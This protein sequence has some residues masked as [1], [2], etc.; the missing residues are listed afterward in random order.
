MKTLSK[1]FLLVTM[2]TM[3][4]MFVTQY[5]W[6]QGSIEKGTCTRDIPA[7]PIDETTWRF[8]I[9]NPDN[10]ELF[11]FV[12]TK[13]EYVKFYTSM[14][15]DYDT[16]SVLFDSQKRPI[17]Q[18]IDNMDAMNFDN[19]C[20]L[21]YRV[22]EGDTYYLGLREFYG[23]SI[24]NCII[25]VETTFMAYGKAVKQPETAKDLNVKTL[26]FGYN[27][28]AIPAI[29]TPNDWNVADAAN[30]ELFE[31]VPEKSG[32]YS[33]S[34]VDFSHTM[35]ALFDSDK[36]A[37]VLGQ[38]VDTRSS[39]NNFILSCDVVAGK[40]YYV[41]VRDSYGREISK[42]RIAIKTCEEDYG[43]QIGGVGNDWIEVGKNIRNIGAV[44][45]DSKNWRF[46]A[47]DL[48]SYNLFKFVA[49]EQAKYNFHSEGDRRTAAIIYDENLQPLWLSEMLYGV[50]FTLSYPCEKGRTY[51][52]GVRDDV[53][54][55]IEKLTIIVEKT[56]DDKGEKFFAALDKNIVMG[57]NKREID[58]NPE[59]FDL[60]YYDGYASPEKYELYCF[61][62][63]KSEKVCFRIEGEIRAYAMLFD[64][65][66]Q[67][68]KRIYF[69][70]QCRVSYDLVE[71]ETYYYGVHKNYGSSQDKYVSIVV[72]P[73][74]EDYG[75]CPINPHDKTLKLGT[76]YKFL[77]STSTD[78]YYLNPAHAESPDK[79]D[80][81]EFVATESGRLSF[82]TNYEEYPHSFYGL[83]LDAELKP[84]W[85][86]QEVSGENKNMILSYDVVEG[87]TY[88][89]GVRTG[90]GWQV[91]KCPVIVE[92]CGKKYGDGVGI[93][94][95]NKI[96]YGTNVR[97]IPELP[98][99]DYYEEDERQAYKM[100]EFVAP[101]DGRYLF[102]TTGNESTDV[103]LYDLAFNLLQRGVSLW[104]ALERNWNGVL[105]F[106]L[107]K[108]ET[109][110]L[111]VAESWGEP[112][113]SCY[114]I[115]EKGSE[116]Y[117]LPGH[118]TDEDENN[119]FTFGNYTVDLRSE[120]SVE[121]F[122]N[123]KRYITVNPELQQVK[124]VLNNFKYEGSDLQNGMFIYCDNHNLMIELHGKN[125]INITDAKFFVRVIEAGGILFTGDG[126]LEINVAEKVKDC[127]A[128]CTET[129]GSFTREIYDLVFGDEELDE[130]E[131]D[132]VEGMMVDKFYG[133]VTV[134]NNASLY[135]QGLDTDLFI[136][137]S[138]NFELNVT[139][140]DS[141]ALGIYSYDGDYLV[142]G[143]VAVN[144]KAENSVAFDDGEM[145]VWNA[146]LE[147]N[148][149]TLFGEDMS[150]AVFE[151]RMHNAEYKVFAGKDKD[152]ATEVKLGSDVIDEL[153]D[154][155]H[156]HTVSV[157][158]KYED[159]AIYDDERSKEFFDHLANTSTME[160]TP[161]N[162]TV[163]RTFGSGELTTLCLP[164][165]V[166]DVSM[167]DIVAEYKSGSLDSYLDFVSTDCIKAGKPYLVLSKNGL[168]NPTFEKVMVRGSA[169]PKV[170][171]DKVEKYRNGV[172]FY[173]DGNRQTTIQGTFAPKVVEGQEYYY[174][175]GDDYMIH[176]LEAGQEIKGLRAY[177]TS[178]YYFE[179][180][181]SY[182]DGT[183]S[184]YVGV[185][186]VAL[187]QIPAG[188]DTYN[189]Q[190][191]RVKSDAKGIV[192]R[193]GKKYL[194]K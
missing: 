124:L 16:Y 148:A 175:Y 158:N 129:F 26:K 157:I 11:K 190:G 90:S 22:I 15:R 114:I 70:D 107:S 99:I 49:P 176:P 46:D 155:S 118:F 131:L 191:Q 78:W 189:L 5:S 185:D 73:C 55:A 188:G 162:V 115:V 119:M 24:P 27:D 193:N 76:N 72:E 127:S 128:L 136:W 84:L 6:A 62:A 173:D 98:A 110:Y 165:D 44:P 69:D 7:T 174:V 31:Y 132:F 102:Y 97:A 23:D 41:G 139:N 143:K 87:R 53:G 89:L 52:L 61:V 3:V 12:A 8:D 32:K 152:S 13:S 137:G 151:N 65:D 43:D 71:G 48:K 134:N 19:N 182:V 2:M 64:S 186:G 51:Y 150:H 74:S 85:K 178:P 164:F 50:N 133:S 60:N 36:K 161:M 126:S 160:C 142:D 141:L 77:A 180:V 168:V 104:H 112:I 105:S 80:L 47:S 88:Y 96:A 103:I 40:K 149:G 79:Y 172:Y 166:D 130:W 177:F 14:G 66:M 28:R 25:K 63:P 181:S 135:A 35:G 21:G 117:G 37:I 93:L 183:Y 20:I 33:F 34:T 159:V 68:L 4:A 108:G 10:Y 187:D 82:Y 179:P 101:E 94:Y 121:S 120:S 109:Y 59:N 122:G 56:Q 147:M 194:N 92:P 163:M 145:Y 106:D 192:I 86:S 153:Q 83:L 57:S 91:G 100:F 138:G 45:Y 29:N 169:R 154:Y 170:L 1:R 75:E 42:C 67:T 146:D 171:K 156:L 167:F 17:Q 116:V 38:Y 140:G 54:S 111:G 123:S 9:N 81:Y 95:S 144:C 184:L 39:N 30:Y 18:C 58:P 113:D 125:I